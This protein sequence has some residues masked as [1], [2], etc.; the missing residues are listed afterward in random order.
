MRQSARDAINEGWARR[1]WRARAACAGACAL[2]AFHANAQELRIVPANCSKPVH[3]VAR[4]VPLSTVLRSLSESLNF[5][6]VYRADTDPRVTTDATSLAPDLVRNLAR[7]MNFS[8]EEATDPRCANGR[9]IAKLS[10]LTDPGGARRGPVASARPAWQT[11]EMERIARLG[12]QDYLRSHG[13][14]EKPIEEL[15]VH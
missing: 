8:L 14:A 15:A 7:N 13:A 12:L 3:L 5:T 4:D 1:A 10:V 6:V 9:R 2:V 11:P